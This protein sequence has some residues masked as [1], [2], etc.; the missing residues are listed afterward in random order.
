METIEIIVSN[1]TVKCPH[2]K[3][4]FK[5]TYNL[6]RLIA[7]NDDMGIIHCPRCQAELAIKLKA[8]HK[9]YYI[10]N[11]YKP[12]TPKERVGLIRRLYQE[13]CS[14]EYICKAVGCSQSTIQK[15][16]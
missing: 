7:A 11:D 14:R 1:I 13:G 5:E 10:T 2:C 12:V 6:I 15:Y 4:M 3:H 16:V 8:A 9:G